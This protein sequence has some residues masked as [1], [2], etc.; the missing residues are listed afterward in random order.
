MA[1]LINVVVERRPSNFEAWTV[2][3]RV[4]GL[5]KVSVSFD[6]SK[7]TPNRFSNSL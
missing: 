3:F 7:Y 2:E 5:H 4:A 6:A 1:R